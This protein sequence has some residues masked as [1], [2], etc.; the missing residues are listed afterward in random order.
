MSPEDE[1]MRKGAWL[2]QRPHDAETPGQLLWLPD[3]D[4]NLPL[5]AG[6]SRRPS[7]VRLGS[8]DESRSSL[9][10]IQLPVETVPGTDRLGGYGFEQIVSCACA[11]FSSRRPQKHLAPAMPE[12][13]PTRTSS[14]IPCCTPDC[15]RARLPPDYARASDSP[16][17]RCEGRESFTADKTKGLASTLR[18]AAP[19]GRPACH[20]VLPQWRHD[21]EDNRVGLEPLLVGAWKL[22]GIVVPSIRR[23]DG[24]CLAEI[25]APH[26]LAGWT[27]AY[28]DQALRV[29]EDLPIF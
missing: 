18:R 8:E 13:I 16:I 11:L 23:N 6:P 28:I 26:V 21:V 17:C 3:P 25:E 14:R 2:I 19:S 9:Q 1:R 20:W 27:V 10:V 15:T 4:A 5:E 7:E 22:A 29:L 12:P 24:A